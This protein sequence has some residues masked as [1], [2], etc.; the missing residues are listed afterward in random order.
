L[1]GLK[2]ML[3]FFLEHRLEKSEKFTQIARIFKYESLLFFLE[4]RLEKS[5]KFTQITRICTCESLHFFGTQI[6]K[7]GEI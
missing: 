3:L 5:E 2:L 7:I 4:H 6:R 1:F